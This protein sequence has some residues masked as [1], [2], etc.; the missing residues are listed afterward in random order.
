MPLGESEA[1]EAYQ[2]PVWVTEGEGEGGEGSIWPKRAG[3]PT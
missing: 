3:A 1:S 2:G